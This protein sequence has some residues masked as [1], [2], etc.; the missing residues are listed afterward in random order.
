MI[1]MW[2]YRE[3][4]ARIEYNNLYIIIINPM[5]VCE[6]VGESVCMYVHNIQACCKL[7]LAVRFGGAVVADSQ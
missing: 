1:E 3:N 4:P 2:W 7:C 5:W 6:V